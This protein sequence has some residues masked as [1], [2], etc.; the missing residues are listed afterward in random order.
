[1]FRVL[2]FISVFLF[3]LNAS[4]I[5]FAEEKYIEVIDNSV[6]KRGTLEFIDE[7][8]KLQYKGSDRVLVYEDDS[9]IIQTDDEIQN[10]DLNSNIPLRMVFLLI[11]SIHKNDLEILKEFFT[12]SVKEGITLLKPKEALENYIKVVEFKKGKNLEFITI[13]MT[14]GN[15]TTIRE[16]ND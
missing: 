8:I 12:V 13:F 2:L 5:N 16:I 10:I 15:K 6:L 4:I 14:N 1:M 3:T 9:L 11:E 7:K